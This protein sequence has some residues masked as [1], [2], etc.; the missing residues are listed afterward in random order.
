MPL[1]L[2]PEQPPYYTIDQNLPPTPPDV[3][4]SIYRATLS[5]TSTSAPIADLDANNTLT[6][7][8]WSYVGTGVYRGTKTGA[9]PANKT[10]IT[11]ASHGAGTTGFIEIFRDDVN[12]LQINTYNAA[13][14]QADGCLSNYSVEIIVTP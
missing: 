14:A 5:Q 6:G 12:R 7:I 4:V 2:T 11:T 10:F 9:F 3:G 8:V 13:G 1:D